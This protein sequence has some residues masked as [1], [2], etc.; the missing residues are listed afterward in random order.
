MASRRGRPSRPNL[1][2]LEG[3]ALMTASTLDPTFGTAGLVRGAVD[4]G[5]GSAIS[6]QTALAVQSNGKI[7][8]VGTYQTPSSSPQLAVRRY[9]T[10]GSVDTTFGTNGQTNIPLTNSATSVSM[11]PRSVVINANGSIILAATE[12]GSSATNGIVVQLTTAGVLDSTF[13]TGGEYTLPT[14][15]GNLSAVALQSSGAIVATGVR[16]TTSGSSSTPQ[17]LAIRLTTAGVLDTSFNGNGEL[18]ISVPGTSTSGVSLANPAVAVAPSGQIYV[19]TTENTP[20][21]NLGTLSGMVASINT[22]GTLNTGF[23]SSGVLTL[24]SSSNQIG[25]IA[26]QSDNKIVVAGSNFANANPVTPFL[27]RYSTAGVA[28]TTFKG[29]PVMVNSIT[30]AG[31]FNSVVIGTDGKITTTGSTLTQGQFIVERFQTTGQIDPTFGAK[32]RTLVTV[33]PPSGSSS[34]SGAS[35]GV[36][37][38]ASNKI[39]IVGTIAY[40]SASNAFTYQSVLAQVLPLFTPNQTNADYDNDGKSDISAELTAQ[41]VFAYRKS[42]GTGDTLQAFGSSGVGAS[43]PVAGDFDGDGISDVAVYL[44]VLGAFAYRPSSGGGDVIVP[45][46]PK[47]AGASIPCPADYDGDGKTDFAVYIPSSGTYAYRPSSNPGVDLLQAFGPTGTNGSIPAPGDYDGDGKT[48]I[49]VYIPAQGRL[50]YRPSSGGNDFLMQFGPSGVGASIPA[51]GDYDGDGKTDIAV[52]I[53]AQ[54]AFAIHPSSGVANQLISFGT[55]GTGAS[56]PIPGDYDG[57]GKTDPAIYLVAQG[58]FAYR[59]SAGGGDSLQAFGP[60]GTNAIFPTLSIPY[61]Q[62]GGTGGTSV[63]LVGTSAQ[64]AAVIPLTSDLLDLINGT[65]PTKKKATATTA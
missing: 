17:L 42:N 63:R 65:T 27:M 19:A 53:P 7:V 20:S 24:A 30:P 25:G 15:D 36:A 46:G 31:G 26:V 13:A 40:N 1:E 62:P 57:D 11:A 3:R 59:P 50:A 64:P 52:Y 2:A 12:S 5:T 39:D 34:F 38:G 28:D 56:I 61:A 9:N 45:F 33:S 4:T 16:T 35:Y 32:G 18:A 58:F 6:N 43:I 23:G 54:A 47:G 55:K 10:D 14:A 44:P 48:D 37:L 60:T 49:A 41:G 22:N 51:P 29:L 8:T 21:S